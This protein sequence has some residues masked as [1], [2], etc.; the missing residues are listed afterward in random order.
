LSLKKYR[1]G[2][3]FPN[4]IV[5]PERDRLNISALPFRY[6]NPRVTF[7]NSAKQTISKDDGQ[8]VFGDFI[9]QVLRRLGTASV[10]RTALAE[11]WD[12][13]MQSTLDAE[14]LLFCEAAGAAGLDPYAC[15]DQDASA[16]EQA[17]E[18]FSH[19]NLLEFLSGEN[20]ASRSSRVIEDMQ[21]DITWYRNESRRIGSHAAL[22]RLEAAVDEVVTDFSV[23][24]PYMRGYLTAQRFRSF[25]DVGEGQKL[26]KV[27]EI[28]RRLGNENFEYSEL[29][30][31]SLRGVVEPHLE[32]ARVILPLIRREDS[33]IFALA[34]GIGDYLM[35]GDTG[36]A[37]LTDTHSDRQAAGRAFAAEF[38]APAVVLRELERNGWPE[39]EIAR[40]FGV[41]EKVVEW[42]LKNLSLVS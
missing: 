2:F 40:E 1:E 17:A 39:D 35:F 37:P 10:K 31:C 9:E 16:I 30:T 23:E 14:E 7:L 33:K 11:R 8:V 32:T 26:P 22:P 12:L 34:R 38:L 42:Q 5:E 29:P 18:V 3:I 13:I 4:L 28:T 41:G 27:A 24:T 6:E 21:S 25:I 19:E 36:P 20:A 15:S